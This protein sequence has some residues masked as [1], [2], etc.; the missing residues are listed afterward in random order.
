MKANLRFNMKF[1]LCLFISLLGFN[2][3][4]AQET[5]RETLPKSLFAPIFEPA[6]DYT[7]IPKKA[8][9]KE[10]RPGR[11]RYHRCRDSA[12]IY[13]RAKQN[14]RAKNQPL[15][16]V[17]GFDSCPSCAA[18]DREIFNPKRPVETRDVIQYFTGPEIKDY[19]DNDRPLT[20]S[21][22]R[23][24]A[25]SKH[26]LRLADDLGV[27]KMAE[28]RGWYR[29]WSPFLLFVNPVSGQLHSES[30]WE[31]KQGYCNYGAIIAVSIEGIGMA[32][33][34]TPYQER[35]RCKY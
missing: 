35:R 5:P 1:L 11:T 3:A 33:P 7:A 29:V 18:L 24:H 6:L 20:I 8:K 2:L 25:R 4:A 21:V 31:S 32:K 14:A 23:I 15:M 12:Q 26:G 34:G 30:Y 16:V 13:A 9:C 28:D 27:T 19:L 10:E 22:V 17:F